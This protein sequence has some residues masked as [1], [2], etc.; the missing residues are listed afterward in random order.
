MD[1]LVDALWIT[2][3]L[4]EHRS[5]VVGFQARQEGALSGFLLRAE[6][7]PVLPRM[8]HCGPIDSSSSDASWLCSTG[9]ADAVNE[10]RLYRVRCMG[11][12]VDCG[13]PYPLVANPQI[14]PCVP[15]G[16]LCDGV[17]T[18]EIALLHHRRYR[19]SAIPDPRGVRAV[20]TGVSSRLLRARGRLLC[21]P[22][23]DGVVAS[24][25]RRCSRLRGS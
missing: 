21:V 6:S 24:P 10:Q 16:A 1:F 13:Y 25:I 20:S 23:G 11:E 17:T 12:F 7:V 19:L 5:I 9:I 22:Q 4:Q 2:S 3:G 18:Y 14:R 8:K 15:A